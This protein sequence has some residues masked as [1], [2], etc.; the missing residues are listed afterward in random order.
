MA[1]K[2]LAFVLGGGGARGALQVGALRALL[3]EG[4]TPDLL[5]GTSIGAVNATY[6]ALHGLNDHTLDELENVWRDTMEYNL[7]PANYL[8]LSVRAVFGQPDG[9]TMGRIREFILEHGLTEQI[10][11]ADIRGIELYLVAADLNSGLPILY[12]C[13]AGQSV[14]E[15]VLASTAL[16]PWVYPVEVD[17][18]MVVDGGFASNLPIEPAMTCGATEIIALDLFDPLAVNFDP[19]RKPFLSKVLASTIKRQSAL[20]MALAEARGVDVKVI[21][22]MADYDVKMW[23]FSKTLELIRNGYDTTQGV[24]EKWRLEN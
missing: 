9:T 7:L 23:D 12:G 15:G 16:P 4:I 3:E 1:K 13:D 2:R 19:G 17:G 14:L 18:K 6:L 20:E 10:R 22:L 11:F 5:V 21:S 24:L 8:W